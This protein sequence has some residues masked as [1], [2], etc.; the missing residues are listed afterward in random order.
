MA[1]IAD[2]LSRAGIRLDPEEF[3]ALVLDVA[4]ALPSTVEPESPQRELTRGEVEAL[5]RGGVDVDA[6]E[7]EE[8]PLALTAAKY[9]ALLAQAL[10]VPDAARMLGVNPSRIR[11]RLAERTLYGIRQRGGWRLPAFQFE[12]GRTVPGIDQVLPRLDPKL[13]P[14]AAYNWF[15]L[16]DPDLVLGEDERAVSPRDWLLSGG[17]PSEVAEIAASL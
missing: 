4:S 13:H 7:P 5:E 12:R 17:N 15:T 6:Q 14:V 2:E 16:P 10:T 3:E 8:D 11:Q 9:T 1:V